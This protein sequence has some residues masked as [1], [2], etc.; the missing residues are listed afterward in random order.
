MKPTPFLVAMA[1]V[2]PAIS[3]F[4]CGSDPGDVTV[5]PDD[6]THGAFG[7]IESWQ[8]DVGTGTGGTSGTG[9]RGSGTA[10]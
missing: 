7:R 10:Y 6:E 1:T 5:G 9:G 4:A 2:M 3:I 8:Q